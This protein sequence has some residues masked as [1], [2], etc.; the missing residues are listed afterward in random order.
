M[1]TSKPIRLTSLDA[2]TAKIATIIL[3]VIGAST[4][5]LLPG[6]V[7]LIAESLDLRPN[8]IGWVASGDLTTMGATMVVVAFVIH[9][10][11]WR[12]L[13]LAALALL[14]IG[15][16]FSAFAST[17]QTMMYAR[18]LSGV[19]E[20]I[21]VSVAFTILGG[22][23][24]PDRQFGI[25]LV[26]ALTFGATGLLILPTVA[27]AGGQTL[28]FGVLALLVLVSAATVVWLPRK[29]DESIE[30]ESTVK[31]LPLTLIGLG[32]A[33]VFFYFLAQGDVWA[34]L[35]RIGDAAQLTPAL[36]GKALALSSVAGIAGAF[37]ATVID[38]RFG[39]AW[40]LSF[41]AATSI[42]ALLLLHAEVTATTF[43]AAAAMFNFAWNV[44]Q[45]LF[46]GIM[47]ELD[48]KGRAVC[49]MGA[50]QT[51]G[52]GLGPGAAALFVSGGYGVVL[53]IGIGAILISQILVLTLIS[54]ARRASLAR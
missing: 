38:T 1:N 39:R 51:I 46:S 11:D 26:C 43:I 5:L 35:E 4:I 32:L 48:A 12:Y 36:V 41:S 28:V 3:G 53:Y 20:G 24:N 44:S 14:A 37:V 31:H 47:A 21:G 6:L 22:M 15:Y 2:T 13:T 45:P 19:G 34:Y 54:L 8:Q 10:I 25:Y 18:L 50:V 9:R 52:V 42:T 27:A 7:G 40:P 29:H 30:D 23:H 33:T 16:G 49:M 17:F